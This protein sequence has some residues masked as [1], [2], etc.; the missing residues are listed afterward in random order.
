MPRIL[1]TSKSLVLD[2]DALNAISVDASLQTLLARRAI[3]NQPSIL[4]P[5]SLEAARLL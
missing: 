3:K 5:H 2:A 4:M 1:S